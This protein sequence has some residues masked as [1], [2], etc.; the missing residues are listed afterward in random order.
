MEKGFR[1]GRRKKVTN[2]WLYSGGRI[3]WKVA[4]CLLCW[5]NGHKAL[6]E[7]QACTIYCAEPGKNKM[8]TILLPRPG[9][10]CSQ[11]GHCFY[12][13][14]RYQYNCLINKIYHLMNF[15]LSLFFLKTLI[16][17]HSWVVVEEWKCGVFRL[18][19]REKKWGE[20]QTHSLQIFK[21]TA[22]WGPQN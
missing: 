11:G 6:I 10:A 16:F 14:T 22:F 1:K 8:G 2:G 12:F 15:S 5:W 20:S 9:G 18:L 21:M 19:K 17:E 4:V 3:G 13:T 7:A